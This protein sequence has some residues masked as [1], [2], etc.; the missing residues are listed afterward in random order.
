MSLTSSHVDGWY[1][2]RCD[3]YSHLSSATTWRCR[4][5]LQ[6]DYVYRPLH[7]EP[8]TEAEVTAQNPFPPWVKQPRETNEF[9]LI[10]D[11]SDPIDEVVRWAQIAI[12]NHNQNYTYFI[13]KDWDKRTDEEREP[14]YEAARL[15]SAESRTDAKFSPNS[16]AIKVNGPGLPDLSFYDMPGVFRNARH[17]ED[18]FLVKVVE[19]LAK[20]YIARKNAI[21]LWAVPM[22]HDPETSSTFTLIR[23]LRAQNRTIGVLTKAD[24]LPK[25]GHQQWLAMLAGKQ[26]QVG[27]GYFITS[28]AAPDLEDQDTQRRDRQS[29][30]EEHAAEEAFFNRQSEDRAW[31]QEFSQFD[32][33]CGIDQLVKFL[34]QTLA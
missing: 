6:Q 23:A 31:P 26:H 5:T 9:K 7:D 11:K 18:Q 19:N 21:I 8:I 20:E 29:L 2:D 17:E 32:D 10:L 25:G 16:V 30:R 14:G 28:R 34:A 1:I 24:L 22:N 3:A 27:K 12:L 33:R 13:P 4:I 15:A